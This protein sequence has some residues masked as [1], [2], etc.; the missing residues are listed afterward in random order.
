MGINKDQIKGRAEEAKGKVKEV[1]GKAM[2][3][4]DL[5][6]KGSIQKNL[7]AVQASVGDMK[8]DLAKKLKTP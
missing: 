1:I 5:E 4:K 6:A 8:E 7:G 2:G 3:N